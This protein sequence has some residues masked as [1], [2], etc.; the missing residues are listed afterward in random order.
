MPDPTTASEILVTSVR[1][2]GDDMYR[3]TIDGFADEIPIS[4]PEEMTRKDGKSRCGKR[5]LIDGQWII[6][7]WF[8][9]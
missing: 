6:V 8:V 2:T 3:V 1:S 7:Y 4:Y 5:L 9:D